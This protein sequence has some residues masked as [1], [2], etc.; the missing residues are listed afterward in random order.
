MIHANKTGWFFICAALLP[1]FAA[2]A[3]PT[4]TNEITSNEIWACDG[5][6]DTLWVLTAEGVNCTYA[7]ASNTV[8]W[9]GYFSRQI[10]DNAAYT[11]AY[12]GGVCLVP[13]GRKPAEAVND[14]LVFTAG[15]PLPSP[16]SMRLPYN[17]L[18]FEDSVSTPLFVTV[19]IDWAGG[20]FWMACMDGG[21][22]RMRPGVDTIVL[23]PGRDSAYTFAT[24]T[25][26]NFP[27]IPAAADS[28]VIAV[29]ADPAARGIWV[30]RRTELWRLSADSLAWTL[31][32]THTAD[33]G[34]FYDIAVRDAATVF[35]SIATAAAPD[36]G[37]YIY[38]AAPGG[39][40]QKSLF[41][42]EK[43]P[44]SIT[45]LDSGHMYFVQKNE[46]RHWLYAGTAAPVEQGFVEGYGFSGSLKA[47]HIDVKSPVINSLLYT[48]KADTS[49]LWIATSEG[50]FRS[51][52]VP[53]RPDSLPNLRIFRKD[54]TAARGLKNRNVYAFPG[55]LNDSYRN[56]QAV[57]AY[58]LEKDDY[59]TID[60]YDWNMDHVTRVLDDKFRFAGATRPDGSG[61]STVRSEDWW[62]GTR[63]NRGGAVVAPG[64]YYFRIMTRSGERA[65]GK[66]VVAKPGK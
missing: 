40:W 9:Q 47:G 5:G 24:F 62:D 17:A 46:I 21:L 22:V 52:G 27:H 44:Y 54:I 60:I 4:A 45:F 15:A 8:P 26:Q 20:Y 58:N 65:F 39:G 57:F 10:H 41:F 36:S 16:S 6:G 13:L 2:H 48:K 34:G 29:E 14:I 42:T 35:A 43:A 28:Q 66:V 55:I 38:R 32:D 3:D 31:V 37:L 11:L 1:A 33:T 50:L 61:I 30:I 53:L 12:G 64:V 49:L 63:N 19:D 51:L 23:Y 56:Q 18:P 25:K 59:V 7:A